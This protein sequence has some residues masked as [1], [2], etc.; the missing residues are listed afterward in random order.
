MCT[1]AKKE[2]IKNILE[3]LKFKDQ[4]KKETREIVSLA[5][6]FVLYAAIDGLLAFVPMPQPPLVFYSSFKIIQHFFGRR[7]QRKVCVRSSASTG[8]RTY[9][10][11]PLYA[12]HFAN[13]VLLDIWK[14]GFAL[15]ARSKAWYIFRSLRLFCMRSFSITYINAS[16]Y[17]EF[18]FNKELRKETTTTKRIQNQINKTWTRKCAR[19]FLQFNPFY[20]MMYFSPAC[21]LVQ[22]I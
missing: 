11:I 13:F 2:Q 4:I 16:A 12:N 14:N 15:T 6:R 18:A 3:N 17:C 1:Q 5:F 10:Q 21:E 20:Y 8:T 22:H 7:L 9:T 19:I